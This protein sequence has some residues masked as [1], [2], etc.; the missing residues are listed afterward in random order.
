MV[1]ESKQF[2]NKDFW[3]KSQSSGQSSLS[4]LSC[5]TLGSLGFLLLVVEGG[6]GLYEGLD[7]CWFGSSKGRINWEIET[8][9]RK[10]P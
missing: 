10:I 4:E 1:L 3:E 7:Y 8:F 5:R 9:R 2:F 6:F